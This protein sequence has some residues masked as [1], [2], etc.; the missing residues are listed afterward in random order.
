MALVTQRCTS[1]HVHQ[2]TPSDV[3]IAFSWLF[4]RFGRVF[5]SFVW[6]LLAFTFFLSFFLSFFPS[7]FLVSRCSHATGPTNACRFQRPSTS[8]TRCRNSIPAFIDTS[9]SYPKH[10]HIKTLKTKSPSPSQSQTPNSDS[11]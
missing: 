9:S 7:F 1:V 5:V 11:P 4:L 8:D 10:Y 6:S 2:P 3:D